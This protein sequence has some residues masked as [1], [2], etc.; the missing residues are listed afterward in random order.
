M[1]LQDNL[2]PA[3]W[4]EVFPEAKLIIPAK[5]AEWEERQNQTLIGLKQAL[6]NAGDLDSLD[7]I[8]RYLVLAFIRERFRPRFE[9]AERI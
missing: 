5:I 6:I 1:N 9:R 8:S 7:E 2:T 3:Q 4:L